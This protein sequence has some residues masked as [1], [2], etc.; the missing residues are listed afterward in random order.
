[1]YNNIYSP[2]FEKKKILDASERYALALSETMR[3][4]GQSYHSTKKYTHTTMLKKRI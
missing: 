1:M 4:E 3:E 2:I